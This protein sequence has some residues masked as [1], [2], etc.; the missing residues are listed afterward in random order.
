MSLWL[1]IIAM[2]AEARLLTQRLA[3]A[4]P[5]GG[6]PAFAG[7]LGQ[8]ELLL[9]LSS[10]GQVNAAQAVTAALEA[11][12]EI[13]GVLNLG[14]GGAYPDSGLSR[15]QAML[16]REV[17][18]ADLGVQTQAHLHGLEKVGIPLARLPQA[19][20][21]YN[22][23]TC[24]PGLSGRLLAAQPELARGVFATVGRVSGDE[25]TA[26]AVA[27]RWGADLEEMESA[28]VALVALH[29]GRPFAALRGISNI[30]GDRA[31][32]LAAGAEAAQRALLALEKV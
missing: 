24:D 1:V 13:A 28:A 26:R 19:G 2:E 7:R 3:P 27:T 22:R 31:L 9:L 21:V 10:L 15:G 18:L 25:A 11:R 14:C 17:V 20:E 4:G 5:I 32:D 30:A 29:Y 12:P 6:R 8:Q 23:L 16:A